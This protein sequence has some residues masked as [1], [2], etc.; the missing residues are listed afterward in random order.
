LIFR[1]TATAASNVIDAG[2]DGSIADPAYFNI[3][4]RDLRAAASATSCIGQ[5]G[6]SVVESAEDVRVRIGWQQK[7]FERLQATTSEYE[8]EKL[9]VSPVPPNYGTKVFH[10]RAASEISRATKNSST[11]DSY[12]IVR[13]FFKKT[14]VE[15]FGCR[16]GRQAGVCTANNTQESTFNRTLQA[17]RCSYSRLQKMS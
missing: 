2:H 9:V 11:W 15:Y 8:E 5:P 6:G 13:Q 14:D 16:L 3:S 12:D 1:I 7:S 10:T 4:E 17:D